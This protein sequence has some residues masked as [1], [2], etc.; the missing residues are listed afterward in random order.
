ME[1][2]LIYG[3]FEDGFLLAAYDSRALAQKDMDKLNNDGRKTY[4]E[5][6]PLRSEST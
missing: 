2:K 3:L 6:F 4:I 1:W 5:S